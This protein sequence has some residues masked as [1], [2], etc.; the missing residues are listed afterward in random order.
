MAVS[1]PLSVPILTSLN[2]Q[3][4]KDAQTQLQKL[5]TRLNSLSTTALKAGA[6][7]AVFQ[8]GRALVDFG[9]NAIE[10]ARDLERNLQ[11]LQTVFGES[12]PQMERFTDAAYRLGLSQSEAAQASTFLG[13]VLK[14]SGF[15]MS[16]TTGI[17]QELVELGTDLA[18][19]YG[20]D[21]QEALLAMTALFRGEYDPIEK[22][23]VAMKQNE[24]EGEKLKLGLEGLT[25]EAER[26]VDQQIRL[27]L[28]FER[29]SDAQ[30]AY[31]RQSNGLF[32]QQQNLVAI[33]RNMQAEAGEK[34]VPAMVSL[35]SALQPLVERL[36][37]LFVS[38]FEKAVPLAFAMTEN[39]DDFEEVLKDVF[40]AI[41]FVVGAMINLAVLI[42]DNIELVTTLAVAAPIAIASFKGLAAV[43]GLFD[44]LTARIAASTVAVRVLRTALITSGIGAIIVGLGFLTEAVLSAGDQFEDFDY[45]LESSK[46]KADELTE[47]LLGTANAAEGLGEGVSVDEILAGFGNIQ[48]NIT[49]IF[50]DAFASGA[51][52]AAGVAAR[53]YVGEFY[54]TIEDEQQKQ[55]AKLELEAMGASQALINAI[56]GSG[57][58]WYKVFEDVI[59]DGVQGVAE[60]QYAFAQTAD[61]LAEI[62]TRVDE[63]NREGDRQFEEAMREFEQA[64]QAFERF[65]QS[66][67][68]GKESFTEFLDGMSVLP[69]FTQAM[70]RFE[71]QAS[72][73]LQ[74]IEDQ[75]K[76]A[77]DN[78]QLL[79]NSYNNLVDYARDEYSTLMQIQ[80]QRDQ[81]LNRRNLAAALIADVE[82]ATVA[83]GNIVNLLRDAQQETQ[84]V[85]MAKVVQDTVQAGKNMRDF[86]VTIISE[87]VEPIEDA[88]SASDLLIDGFQGVVDR[89]R[90]F[91]DNLKALK[92][93]GL[94]PLLFNQLVEA[95]VEAGGETAQALVDGGSDT[96]TEVNSL[97]GELNE[98]GTE[99]G[100]ETAQV[101]YGQGES[102]VD[103]IVEGLDSKLELLESTATTLAN[104]FVTEFSAKLSAGVDAAIA[105]AE[106]RLA[107][108]P[109]R[110]D[111]P[112]ATVD[113]ELEVIEEA[114]N[115]IADA[116]ENLGESLS[117]TGDAVSEAVESVPTELPR[118]LSGMNKPGPVPYIPYSP[119]NLSG[120]DLSEP[121]EPNRPT[122]FMGENPYSPGFFSQVQ[123]IVNANDRAGGAKAGQAAS[124]S[125]KSYIEKSDPRALN[126]IASGR[127]F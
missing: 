5:G 24:I 45:D 104:A 49:D 113:S 54:A 60:L 57:E 43:I 34:L 9:A 80:R 105:K 53:N 93:L 102:F 36:T 22:F 119:P 126:R 55:V 121:L 7:F 71:K 14:Q 84:R 17:T 62:Q 124:E 123:V 33:F 109:K 63:I 16:E 8:G 94:D 85:D 111:F 120:I 20:Y 11:G 19:T 28:L 95:G 82:S 125:L 23:G 127:P 78:G 101:M 74:S 15:S 6:A 61:G 50:P 75:L 88:A 69:T 98:L 37:P 51:S 114:A 35:A 115:G 67:E 103:G 86:R 52:G 13:S 73:D 3:G 87:F 32:V 108:M 92:E 56:L 41:G 89:T 39:M 40:G 4:L 64:Q 26:L 42:T 58:E 27:Q 106:A 83:S 1:R 72:D 21:V 81:L 18:I 30:G 59:A 110:E 77:F 29:G 2:S 44:L 12:T 48:A 96:V 46:S 90:T 117:D 97:F 116:T 66:A 70:G 68:D 118:G 79:E 107:N 31:E 25:G 100:E 76:Q 122:N 91:V 47:S 99:L 112:T 65:K 10:Q 38:I